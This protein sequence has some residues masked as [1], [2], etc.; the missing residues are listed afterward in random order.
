MC[1]RHTTMMKTAIRL[2]MK[3]AMVMSSALVI[4]TDRGDG[5]TLKHTI[6]TL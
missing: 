1:S 4:T 6:Y 3:K 5:V 2:K